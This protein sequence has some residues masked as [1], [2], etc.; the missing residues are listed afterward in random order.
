M[1]CYL[2]T[3]KGGRRGTWRRR[4]GDKTA[5]S[6]EL[7]FWR[8]WRGRERKRRRST[9]G[10]ITVD[11]Q[12]KKG[13]LIGIKIGREQL[14]SYLDRRHSLPTKS[15]ASFHPQL[16]SYLKLTRIIT[17]VVPH[18]SLTQSTRYGYLVFGGV[19]NSTDSYP[20]L[21]PALAPRRKPDY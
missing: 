19:A 10:K 15:A 9:G 16:K 5:R 2:V 13:G 6:A 14:K 18:H 17:I 1:R 4:T 21:R 7:T 20:L 11:G 3:Y 12:K 8:R